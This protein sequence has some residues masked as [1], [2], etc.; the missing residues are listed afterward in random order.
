[1]ESQNIAYC[2]RKEKDGFM[3]RNNDDKI[4]VPTKGQ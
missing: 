4:Y 2:F 1:M 3:F